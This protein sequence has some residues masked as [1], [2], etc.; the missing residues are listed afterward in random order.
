[1]PLCAVYGQT[2]SIVFKQRLGNKSWNDDSWLKDSD[3]KMFLRTFRWV[4]RWFPSLLLFL[5]RSIEF[6]LTV[7]R[8]KKFWLGPESC[9]GLLMVWEIVW[10]LKKKVNTCLYSLQSNGE[11]VK[12]TVENW[13]K[14]NIL[15]QYK[16]I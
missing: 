2:D 4:G 8:C 16:L 6:M 1:M 10:C 13:Y 15:L 12:F 9:T 14:V 7:R 3:W 11:I 5:D